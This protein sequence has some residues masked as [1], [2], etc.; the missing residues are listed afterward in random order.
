MATLSFDFNFFYD[1][2]INSLDLAYDFGNFKF[3]QDMIEC[4][5]DSREYKFS[6]AVIPRHIFYP[7]FSGIV[8]YKLKDCPG[9]FK[10]KFQFDIPYFQIST[11]ISLAKFEGYEIPEILEN[12]FPNE[13]RLI[14][15]VK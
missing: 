2:V 10:L 3:T 7:E 14:N 1:F 5:K 13:E 11:P 4:I 15:Y 8:A 12:L 9:I 6:T